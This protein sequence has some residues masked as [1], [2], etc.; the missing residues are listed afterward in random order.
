MPVPAEFDAGFL[1]AEPHRVRRTADGEHDLFRFEAHPAGE[2]PDQP[3]ALLFDAVEDVAGDDADLALEVRLG[4]AVA[5]ILVEPA[6]D[7]VSA[8]GRAWCRRRDWRICRRTRWRCSRR[9]AMMMLFGKRGR[10]NA[11]LDVMTCARPGNSFPSQGL[12]PV[13]IRILPAVTIRPDFVSLT[14]LGPSTTARSSMMSTPDLPRFV[15]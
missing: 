8:I 9:P 11:S 5:Q 4:E 3:R 15:R 7:F 1:Q 12:P 13:A 10:S 14:A 2:M 6:Q